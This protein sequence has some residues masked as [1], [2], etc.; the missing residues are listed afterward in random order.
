[1]RIVDVKHNL[2]ELY[3]QLEPLVTEKTSTSSGSNRTY[4]TIQN[5]SQI[6]NA[7]VELKKYEFIKD[8]VELIL[9]TEVAFQA[10]KELTLERNFY[11]RFIERLLE[12]KDILL[13]SIEIISEF[14]QDDDANQINVK[15][16]EDLSLQGFIEVMEELHYITSTCQVIKDANDKQDTVIRRVDSGSIWLILSANPQAIAVIG[17]LAIVAYGAF[18][19][20]VGLRKSLLDLQVHQSLVHNIKATGED[21]EKVRRDW[22]H[23]A[24]KDSIE[25]GE[26][27]L[28]DNEHEKR[29][30]LAKAADK[31][32]RLY[33]KGIEVHASLK[34]PKEAASSFPVYD[35]PLKLAAKT[36]ELAAKDDD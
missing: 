8:K 31:L 17:S 32:A 16:P 26:F 23:N 21:L 24:I 28:G 9:K 2:K 15:L 3:K 19:M 33:L 6:H 1:M 20:Y 25:N 4:H 35:E 5:W 36:L 10:S 14:F 13:T 18:K 34:A 22:I 7:L 29:D 12:V 27:L 11:A 30:Q